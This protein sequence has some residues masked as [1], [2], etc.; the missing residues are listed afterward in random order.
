MLCS[1][2]VNLQDSGWWIGAQKILGEYKW[3]TRAGVWNKMTYTNWYQGQ[4]DNYQGKEACVE[5]ERKGTTPYGWNDNECSNK[6]P[7]ICEAES[8]QQG[9]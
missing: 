5:I 2:L 3:K 9:R 6:L 1:C 8:N 4:P 7:F